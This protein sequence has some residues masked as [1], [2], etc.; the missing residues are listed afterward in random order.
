MVTKGDFYCAC[1]KHF[2]EHDIQIEKRTVYDQTGNAKRTFNVT[3]CVVDG[4]TMMIFYPPLGTCASHVQLF[5][6][7]DDG[8]WY[9]YD[10]VYD[11]EELEDKIE[12]LEIC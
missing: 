3:K 4:V 2:P 7:T 1:E 12:D 9:L 8:L 6:V 11:V 5:R 10:D